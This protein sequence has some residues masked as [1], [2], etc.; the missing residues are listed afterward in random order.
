[1]SK[2]A[3]LGGGTWGTGL[4]I[5]LGRSRRKAEI[6]LWARESAIVESIR[7]NRENNV[8]LPGMAIPDCVTAS[9]DLNE[10]VDRAH[11]VL[12]VV[13]SANAREVFT[14]ALPYISPEAAIVSAIKGL[15]PA[16]HLRMS[17]VIEQVFSLRFVPR[18]AVLSG[19]SF[20][21]EA[22]RGE[23]TAVALAS[24]DRALAAF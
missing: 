19:P 10:G 9:T 4:S 17:E 14:Q 11:I 22:A 12:G 13:P 20:A 7:K 1:M 23:P 21:I 18:V 2:I 24:H 15:E 5:V 6:A 3:I 16:T 8:Y